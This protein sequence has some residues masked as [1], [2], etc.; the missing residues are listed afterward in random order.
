VPIFLR[1]VKLDSIPEGPVTLLGDA[2]HAMSIFKGE[3]GNHAMLSGIELGELIGK[4]YSP[5]S[6][7]AD[8]PLSLPALFKEYEAKMLTRTRAA[9]GSSAGATS[10]MHTSIEE[11]D[12][13]DVQ[14]LATRGRA[15]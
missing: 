9:I 4:A 2:A 10:W 5:T 11:W 3:G 13:R 15:T 7:P 8:T 12:T 14:A 1:Q 6:P